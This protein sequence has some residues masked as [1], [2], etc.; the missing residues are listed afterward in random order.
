MRPGNLQYPEHLVQW[1]H[2]MRLPRFT[3]LTAFALAA[4]L[5][6]PSQAAKFRTAYD[7]TDVNGDGAVP[8]DGPI[9][10]NGDLFGTTV[11]GGLYGCG[12][13]FKVDPATGAET[14]LYSFANSPD[15]NQ[16][17]AGVTYHAGKLYGTT[18][19]GG[20]GKNAKC[21]GSGCG[22][23]YGF[24]IATGRERVLH[25]FAG[26]KAD[27]RVPTPG[28]LV[29]LNG[30]L[31]GTT[32]YGGARDHGTVYRINAASGAETVVYSFAG[33]TDGSRPQA[34]L[35][36]FAG[37]LYGTTFEG[38]R[39]KCSERCGT[40]FSIDPSTGSETVLHR[41][42]G[43]DG[44]FPF[45]NLVVHGGKLIGTTYLGGPGGGGTVFTINPATGGEHLVFGFSNENGGGVL[46][47]GVIYF[48][49]KLYGTTLGGG[50]GEFGTAFE[51][52]PESGKET[53]LH[54]FTGGADGGL[55]YGSLLALHGVLY[56][57]T[58]QGGINCPGMGC[59]TVF[60]IT[61]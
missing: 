10:H 40:V 47:D 56:G 12:M 30:S 44:E 31:Y 13:I 51:L 14:K 52:D 55:P 45:G 19:E 50:T 38:G 41:F 24:D 26:G 7:F 15:G 34:G 8:E 53:A 58:Y 5:P 43:G 9:S 48:G 61:P 11:V 3:V 18:Y 60:A 4:M 2:K 59:G 22:V 36:Y 28:A 46:G 21:D 27:G 25:S 33:G 35:T 32:Q 37:K 1:R 57:T 23:A 20:S 16:P 54:N 49:G 17:Q 39:L 42:N 29:Y 6:V